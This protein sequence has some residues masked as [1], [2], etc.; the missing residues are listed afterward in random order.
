MEGEHGSTVSEPC[1]KLGR[2]I[3]EYAL[4]GFGE[5]LERRWAGQN[6]DSSSLRELQRT[7]NRRLITEALTDA[8]LPPVDGEAEN[9]RRILTSSDVSESRR[10]DA[11]RRLESEGIDVEELLSD[12]VSHQTVYNHFQSCRNID[13]PDDKSENQRLSDVRSRV[14]GLQNRTELV[15][16]QSLS[17][18]ASHGLLSPGEFDV[19]VDIQVVCE[20]CSRSYDIDSLISRGRCRCEE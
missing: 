20:K 8:G 14:F 3:G 7:V 18:L 4:D 11:R 1:C 2:I 19:V 17:E 15:T 6:G 16:E 9:F 13:G 10:V 5:E 12:F